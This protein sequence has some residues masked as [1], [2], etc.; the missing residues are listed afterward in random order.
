MSLVEIERIHDDATTRVQRILRG[1]HRA[2]PFF[3]IQLQ[4]ETAW[5]G[6]GSES[7]VADARESIRLS[8]LHVVERLALGRSTESSRGLGSPWGMVHTR[9]VYAPG[10]VSVTT[11]EHGG[12][13][14]DP[15]ANAGVP[16]ALRNANG[17][18]E[19][20]SE[21]AK[22]AFAYPA[23][24]TTY[25]RASARRTLRNDEPD[26]YTALTG[27]GIPLEE[28]YTLRE[29]AFYAANAQRYIGVSA[30]MHD[31][32][33]VAVTAVRGGARARQAGTSGPEKCFLVNKDEYESRIGF[34][35]VIDSSRHTEMTN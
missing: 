35:F 4:T 31:A 33:T 17:V 25:E 29:R 7:S 20:D 24:F 3:V 8:N 34:G 10:I 15:E 18:Y 19:E 5:L 30:R 23:L 27:E 6:L 21:W 2:V 12:F 28:S 16:E 14:L 13:L 11:A 1:E 9:T 32:D 26:A 22:V